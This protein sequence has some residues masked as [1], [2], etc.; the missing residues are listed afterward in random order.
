MWGA[1]GAGV[2]PGPGRAGAA[3]GTEVR[4]ARPRGPSQA[5]RGQ[6]TAYWACTFTGEQFSSFCL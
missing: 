5:E 4:A 6:G 2:R 1:G 3:V